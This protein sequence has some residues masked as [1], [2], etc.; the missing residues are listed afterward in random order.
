MPGP[1]VDK[2]ISKVVP[3]SDEVVVCSTCQ[4]MLCPHWQ[5]GFGHE[6][7]PDCCGK[8]TKRMEIT[9]P[10]NENETITNKCVRCN[11]SGFI[12]CSYCHERGKVVMFRTVVL[13]IHHH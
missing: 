6:N 7:C 13:W 2:T 3:H 4:G 8:G 1:F 11:G 12:A 5:L 9:L 10:T